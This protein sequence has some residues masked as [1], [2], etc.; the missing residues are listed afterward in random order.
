MEKESLSIML[1]I[2]TTSL[3][4]TVGQKVSPGT[5]ESIDQ[6]DT[7]LVSNIPPLRLMTMFTAITRDQPARYNVQMQ[8]QDDG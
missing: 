6:E 4:K 8:Q 5:R 3:C 2:R 1:L 7:T